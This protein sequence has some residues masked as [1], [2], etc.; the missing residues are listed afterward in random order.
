[1]HALCIYGMHI[2]DRFKRFEIILNR[3]GG[4][5]DILCDASYKNH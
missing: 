5:V 4:M 1:M 3:L 2:D